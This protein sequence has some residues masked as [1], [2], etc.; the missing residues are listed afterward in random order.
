MILDRETFSHLHDKILL[1]L[2]ARINKQCPDALLK[3]EWA[4]RVEDQYEEARRFIRTEMRRMDKNDSELKI[5]R[6]KV[7][8]AMAW[9]ILRA[10]PFQYFGS[11]VAGRFA[12]EDM[13]LKAGIGVVISFGKSDALKMKDEQLANRYSKPFIFP[14]SSDG[15][16][17]EH[18]LKMLYQLRSSHAQNLFL[19]SNL[20]FVLEQYHLAVNPG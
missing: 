12:N 4:S 19:L 8:A 11:Q 15:P 7:G 14:E 3:T 5:D 20:F 17:R 18:A 16:Y 6:H 1:P 9:A 10:L 2:T 13:A